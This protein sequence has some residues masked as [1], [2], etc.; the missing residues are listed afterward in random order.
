MLWSGPLPP[1]R[2]IYLSQPPEVGAGAWPLARSSPPPLTHP[3]LGGRVLNPHL[4]YAFLGTSWGL[5]VTGQRPGPDR[6]TVHPC[7][8]VLPF[9]GKPD[10]C[11]P[12]LPKESQQEPFKTAALMP[13]PNQHHVIIGLGQGAGQMQSHQLPAHSHPHTE[14]SAGEAGATMGVCPQGGRLDPRTKSLK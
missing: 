2:P 3:F 11:H 1:S 12:H 7:R 5:R 9:Q 6:V 8:I 13:P 4:V 14:S 10:P